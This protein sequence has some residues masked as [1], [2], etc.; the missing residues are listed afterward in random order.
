MAK[1]AADVNRK[2][3]ELLSIVR[4][5]RKSALGDAAWRD[6]MVFPRKLD[7]VSFWL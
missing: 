6:R 2:L 1:T 4:E 7:R 3:S 5:G